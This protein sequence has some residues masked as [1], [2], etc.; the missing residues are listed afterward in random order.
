MAKSPT[1]LT[2]ERLRKEGFLCEVT[3][4]WLPGANVR[5]DLF[6]FIDILAIK[7]GS[8]LAVQATSKANISSRVNKI[9]EHENIA[10]VR[11][12][13]WQIEVWGWAKVGNRWAV[14]VRDVS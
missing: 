11:K 3:E 9:A 14:T 1:Q 13:G 2:L 6:G 7:D 4:K 5:K 12:L 8:V 10:E